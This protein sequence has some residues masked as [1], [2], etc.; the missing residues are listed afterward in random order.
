MTSLQ[1]LGTTPMVKVFI[2]PAQSCYTK[3]IWAPELHYLKDKWYIYFAAD[4]GN[5]AIHRM[6]VLEANADDPQGSYAYKGQLKATTDLWAIDGTVL[7]Y[8]N[9]LYFIWSSWPG[10]TDGVQN[11]YIAPMSNPYTISGERVLI[12]TPIYDWEKQGYPWINEGPQI[13][14]KYDKVFIIYSASHC[15]LN[16]YC[17]GQLELVGHDPLAPAAWRKKDK[18]VFM[19]SLANNV[20]GTGHA[21]FTKSPNQQEDWIVYHAYSTATGHTWTDRNVRAQRFTW[22]ANGT[23]SFGIPVACGTVLVEPALDFST[24]FTADFTNSQLVNWE[25]YGGTWTAAK[26]WLSVEAGAGHKLIARDTN[27]SDFTFEALVAVGLTDSIL[28]VGV[29]D[30]AVV[31]DQTIHAGLLFRITDPYLGAQAYNGYY[32]GLNARVGSVELGRTSFGV[33]TNLAEFTGVNIKPGVFYQVKIMTKG[34]HM[35]V[36]FDGSTN[37]LIDMYDATYSAGSIGIRVDQT[38]AR[39]ARLKVIANK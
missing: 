28:N 36:Y 17:L 20:Y 1:Q 33:C 30:S 18:P 32:I 14:R 26:G 10:E 29:T 2:P 12:S 37:P 8:N 5:N 23:P 6:H 31:T 13:L 3:D 21:S 25:T 4:D 7:D 9:R 19:Q 35:R 11:L 27:F 16:E 34:N 38:A 15:S 24:S 39:F 22:N